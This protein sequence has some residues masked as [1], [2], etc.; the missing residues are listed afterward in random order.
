MRIVPYLG[1]V[2]DLPR[3]VV[4]SEHPSLDGLFRW[5]TGW[6]ETIARL[7]YVRGEQAN[8]WPLYPLLSRVL[9]EV[10]PLHLHYCMLLVANLAS[11]GSFL[12][13]YR[14]FER[15]ADKE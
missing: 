8:F 10:T 12:V 9:S 3:T 5:D 6:Y 2:G 7:G 15:L 1:F 13:L 11:L 4:V 14:L